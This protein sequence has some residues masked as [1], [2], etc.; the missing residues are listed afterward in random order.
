ML[1]RLACVLAVHGVIHVKTIFRDT[2]RKQ[3]TNILCVPRDGT[4]DNAYSIVLL[5][6]APTTTVYHDG[7]ILFNK[8]NMEQIVLVEIRQN[9]E[10][11]QQ[12]IRSLGRRYRYFD[13]SVM[14]MKRCDARLPD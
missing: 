7:L 4:F 8:F 13:C 3:A 9:M 2:T 1:V 12:K 14:S 5:G 11:I 10:R 6:T